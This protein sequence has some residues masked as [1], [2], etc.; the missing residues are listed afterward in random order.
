M[1]L[2]TSFVIIFLSCSLSLAQECQNAF[3]PKKE[4][5]AHTFLCPEVMK[6]DLDQLHKHILETHPNPTYYG[7]INDLS[8]AYQVAKSKINK[9][10][11]VFEFTL[12]VNNYLFAL[13]DSHTGINPKQ[14]L[15]EVN[16][17]RKVLPFFVETINNKFYISG[18]YNPDFIRGAEL[19]QIDTFSVKQLYTYALALSLS[20][21]DATAAKEEVAS[22]YIGVVYNL[23]SMDLRGAKSAKVQMVSPQGDTLI[24]DIAFSASWRY[25]LASIFSADDQEVAYSF[26]QNN[27]GILVVASFQPLSLNLYKKQIDAFFEEV[28]KRRCTTIYID[29]RNNLGGLLRA[30]EYLFSYINTKQTSVKTNYLY[31]RSDYD[32]FALLSPM[33]QMQ[34]ETR[35]KN[36]YPNGL[37]SK[38]YDFYKLPK[39]ATYTIL[40]DYLP[41]NERNYVFKGTCNLVVNGNSMSASVLFAAWFKHI[42]RGKIL[43]T[44]CMGGVGG[45]FGNPAIITLKHSHLDVMVATLKFTPFHVKERILLPINPDIPIKATREDIIEQ[46][47]PFME[48]LKTYQKQ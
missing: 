17:Q 27:N 41:E 11:S 40:Y 43:G 32:R 20:E 39:G 7:N 4:L 37:I 23:L 31:K 24:R 46:R 8:E 14:F 47:D 9:P 26:D 16:G 5:A 22:E 38:E 42:E 44:P 35:A 19:L 1:R 13:K 48:Y 29:L 28:E 6:A 45:T 3:K 2:W 18:G 25:F 30:E 21:G 12:V 36:V 33:Q 10:L 34:F 15:Y